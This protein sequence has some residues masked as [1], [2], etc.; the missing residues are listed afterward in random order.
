MIERPTARLIVLDPV[1]RVLL[2]RANI[3]HS[4]E[5]ELRP[6]AT[7]FLALPGGGIEPG[8]TPIDAARREL[9]EET[10]LSADGE[11]PMV[12]VRTTAYEWKGLRYFTRE[13]IFF[14][15]V[16]TDRIDDSG[17]LDGDRRWMSDLGWWTIDALEQ[18]VEIV[19]P[20][21]LASLV[22]DLSLGRLPPEPIVL[23]RVE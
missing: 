6:D 9:A 7:T 5:P 4:V 15:R 18:T 11:L 21:G 22:R 23:G 10:G 2:F 13:H 1:G 17:W 16:T 20:P 3:G 8:E 12:A 14:L 19:R